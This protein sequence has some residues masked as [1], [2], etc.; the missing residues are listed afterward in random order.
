MSPV[1]DRFVFGLNLCLQILWPKL[2]NTA[3]NVPPFY[4]W[5]P[6][7]QNKQYQV[8]ILGL[9]WILIEVCRITRELIYRDPSLY[10][11]TSKTLP[12]PSRDE[13]PMLPM[14]GWLWCHD[15]ASVCHV[16]WC[17]RQNKMAPDWKLTHAHT[18][19][20]TRSNIWVNSKDIFQADV[21]HVGPNFGFILPNRANSWTM[22]LLAHFYVLRFTFSC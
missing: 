20:M 2:W 18:N 4:R 15:V 17:V 16:M 13:D 7:N 9:R 21:Q 10:K 5:V 12:L 22:M 19:H 3:S 6:V 14:S 8:N 11:D 1:P